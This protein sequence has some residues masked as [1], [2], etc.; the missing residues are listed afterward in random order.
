M[1]GP[2]GFRLQN[3]SY[4]RDITTVIGR[5][6]R[7]SCCIYELDYLRS[8]N[9]SYQFSTMSRCARLVGRNSL[10]IIDELATV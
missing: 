6:N 10:V 7:K 4:E 2:S 8:R 1:N 9:S 3:Q 5:I